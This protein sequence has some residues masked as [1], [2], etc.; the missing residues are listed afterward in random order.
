MKGSRRQGS[1]CVKQRGIPPRGECTSPRGTLSPGSIPTCQRE[2]CVFR[3]LALQSHGLGCFQKLFR[4]KR[5]GQRG[6]GSLGNFSIRP[7][8][9]ESARRGLRTGGSPVGVRAPVCRC[10]CTLHTLVGQRACRKENVGPRWLALKSWPRPLLTEGPG[11][12]QIRV[13]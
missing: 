8:H 6:P 11:A 7:G 1:H 10:V 3:N 5:N 12:N 13:I 4:Q 9:P 2:I